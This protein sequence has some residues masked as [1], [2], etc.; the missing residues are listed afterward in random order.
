M[1]AP[2]RASQRAAPP[3]GLTSEAAKE[4]ERGGKT[5]GSSGPEASEGQI[6]VAVVGAGVMGA[7]IA[8]VFAAGGLPVSIYDPA[9]AALGSVPARVRAGL[10]QVGTPPRPV[11][12]LLRTEAALAAAVSQADLVIE[13]AP[14]RLAVKQE[15]FAEL[16]RLTRPDAI[17][18]SNT[19][20]IPIDQIA[21]SVTRPRRVIGTHFWQPPHLVPLVEVVRPAA[22][23]PA[24]A[25]WTVDLLTRIGMRPVLVTGVVGNRLQH[26]LKREA[27]ALVAD[28]ICSAET[29]DTVTRYGFGARLGVLG[30]LEQADLNGLELTLAI[31]E[32]IMPTLDRT[33]TAHP[34]LAEKVRRGHTGAAAG[35]GFRTWRPGEAGARR[36]EIARDLAALAR[37]RRRAEAAQRTQPADGEDSA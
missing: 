11:L 13:A 26:A 9:P 34:L 3:S 19:S 33:A 2:A 30:P 24:C 5:A 29:V 6:K 23:D 10:R 16:D 32:E 14:E 12:R 8:Q 1:S 31:H 28:G 15:I 18:A 25:A 4:P 27:I 7:G 35:Q 36:R 21:S 37:R 22:A 20:A 17:L